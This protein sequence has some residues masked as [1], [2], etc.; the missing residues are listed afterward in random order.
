MPLIQFEPTRLGRQSFQNPALSRINC[1]LRSSI[2]DGNGELCFRSIASAQS[3]QGTTTTPQTL[4]FLSDS[5]IYLTC[6]AAK[7]AKKVAHNFKSIGLLGPCSLSRAVVYTQLAF[8]T[9]LGHR[10]SNLPFN[11]VSSSETPFKKGLKSIMKRQIKTAPSLVQSTV[12]SAA[13]NA[14]NKGL[15]EFQTPPRPETGAVGL[16]C[17]IETQ[18]YTT[19]HQGF[20]SDLINLTSSNAPIASLMAAQVAA[21]IATLHL[22]DSP[23]VAARHS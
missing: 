2:F 5:L 16:V 7:Y 17:S 19:S 11:P 6:R 10:V 3:R 12:Q 8:P 22:K 4:A 18:C 1:L 13:P 20:S 21:Q 9:Y 15:I 14:S 23:T